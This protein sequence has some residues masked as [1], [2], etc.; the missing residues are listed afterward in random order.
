MLPDEKLCVLDGDK[1]QV[2]SEF[3]GAISTF[4]G[5]E[6]CTEEACGI[7]YVTM[8]DCIYYVSDSGRLQE[9][10]CYSVEEPDIEPIAQEG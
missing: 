7:V 4:V 1:L 10:L 6:Q 5:V 2:I 3:G 9:V 8:A